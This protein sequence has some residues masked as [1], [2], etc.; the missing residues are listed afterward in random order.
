M[1]NTKERY[2]LLTL[3]LTPTSTENNLNFLT[4]LGRWAR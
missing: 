1:N 2:V 3:C 4:G